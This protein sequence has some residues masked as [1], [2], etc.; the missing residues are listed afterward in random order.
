MNPL[1]SERQRR[2]MN[3]VIVGAS[4]ENEERST[5]L[6]AGL[7]QT[8]P[9]KAV[10]GVANPVLGMIEHTGEVLAGRA[11][12]G[13]VTKPWDFVA[14]AAGQAPLTAQ[15]GAAGIFGGRLSK[16]AD[17]GKLAEARDLEKAGKGLDEIWEKTGWY[18]DRDKHWR[19]EISD[20]KAAL[21]DWATESVAMGIERKLGDILQHEDLFK[22]YPHLR[23]IRVHNRPSEG[24]HGTFFGDS[25]GLKMDNRD[26]KEVLSTLLHE[27]QH[28]VQRKEGFAQGG[29]TSMFAMSPE[30]MKTAKAELDEL[31]AARSLVHEAET[32]KISL[33]EA[34][35]LH[36]DLGMTVP[37]NAVMTARMNPLS[38]L[39]K[40][41]T[42][43]EE[44]LK[45]AED[46]YAT[47]RRLLGE[48][49]ARD[50]QARQSMTP[51]DR[52]MAGP[53]WGRTDWRNAIIMGEKDPDPLKGWLSR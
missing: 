37:E 34:I 9:V 16:T 41:L 25:I 48:M 33:D 42:P 49:E 3:P 53:W 12:A 15:K 38:A 1:F 44:A 50:V 5:A 10:Q 2:R 11:D 26:P 18:K 14:A 32:A 40:A 20:D 29:N 27:V 47:Y 28:G 43:R 35:K 22:A 8:W 52:T 19:H 13:D 17:I 45:R 39:E 21:D 7:A 30:A 46:P 24:A 6:N 51:E 23:D 31:R 36:R 4:P